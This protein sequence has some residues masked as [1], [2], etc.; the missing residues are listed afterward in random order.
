MPRV[1]VIVV[2]WNGRGLLERFLPSVL[3]SDYPDLEIVV[4]DNASTDGTAEWL[5]EAH[6]DVTVMRHAENALFA[7][8]NNLAVPHA[9]GDLL[10]FLNNDVEVPAG[11]LGPLVAAFDNPGV[12][13]VQPKLLQ[14]GDRGQFEYAGAS[15]G[16]LDAFGYP[17]T[18]GRLFDTLEPDRGQYD[19]ARDVFWATGAALVVRRAA[20]EAAG[21]FDESFGMHMEEIDLCWRL[22]RAGWRV[23]VEPASEAYHLGGA[24]L[25]QGSPRKMY[26]N[27]RNGLVMLAKNLPAPAF[28]RVLAARRAF[29]AAA[30]ARALAAGRRDEAAAIRRAWR[31]A[32]ERINAVTPPRP[33]ER[34]VLPPYRRSVVVDYFLRGRRRF[35]D[36]PEEGWRDA[37]WRDAEE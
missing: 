33:D 18:R 17:F 20:F 9:T 36:L 31:D 27:V 13:A 22:Q 16:F 26:F 11:W 2:T 19:D 8:G 24:S 37:G 29:D 10:C 23:R 30:A 14:H 6:P 32:R 5:A 15:G 4:A 25:P 35:S 7:R 28:R 21:G 12:A 3:A 34:V 1:S